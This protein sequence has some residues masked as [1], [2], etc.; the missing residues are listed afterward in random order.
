MPKPELD[1]LDV[2][3]LALELVPGS[4]RP[5]PM[6]EGLQSRVFGI[7]VGAERYVLRIG[8]GRA[9][10]D[11]D[12]HAAATFGGPDLPI[13]QVRTIGEVGPYAYCLSRRL[14]GSPVNRLAPET[15]PPVVAALDATLR[16]VWGRDVSRSNGFGMFD[17][18]GNGAYPTWQDYLLDPV[19]VRVAA[20]RGRVPPGLVESLHRYVADSAA[21]CPPGRS[22]LHGDYGSDNTL[23]DGH[24][25]TG[26]LDWELAGYGDWLHDV[27]GILQWEGGEPCMTALARR[28]R[29]GLPRDA[30]TWRRIDCYR[31][32]ICLAE[33]A[34]G[35]EPTLDWIVDVAGSIVGRSH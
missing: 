3:E 9:G 12:A 29:R 5:Y 26:V 18:T 28:L 30:G 24:T 17:H 16:N 4:G 19:P 32:R 33:L 13:P 35:P 21:D 31:A 10:F 20:G 22:L 23:T 15:L 14:A 34:W 25:I 6:T 2:A 7:D 11:K 1:G 8:L 27:A